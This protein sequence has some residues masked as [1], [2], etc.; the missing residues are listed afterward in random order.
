MIRQLGTPEKQDVSFE[1]FWE[2]TIKHS[3]LVQMD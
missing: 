1:I 3:P 2:N